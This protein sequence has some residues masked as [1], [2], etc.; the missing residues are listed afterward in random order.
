M[1]QSNLLLQVSLS[2]IQMMNPI[3]FPI[4]SELFKVK[5]SSAHAFELFSA[6]KHINSI[7]LKTKMNK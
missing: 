6:F 3:L 7:M 4:L 1:L 5:D 2:D